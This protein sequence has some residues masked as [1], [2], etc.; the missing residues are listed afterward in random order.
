MGGGIDY[1]RW[2]RED[3]ALAVSGTGRAVDVSTYVG[4]PGT[5]T[6]ST[7]ISAF[8]AGVRWYPVT[9]PGASIRP[10]VIGQLGAYVG[11]GTA[12]ATGLPG[13]VV[14][15]EVL[16]APGVY[17]GGGVDFRFG[18]TFVLGVGIGGDLPANFSEEL[19]GTKNYRAFQVGISFGFTFGKGRTPPAATATAGSGPACIHP[20]EARVAAMSQSKT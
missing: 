11:T 18:N 7:T 3:L 19:A 20:R 12:T 16:V 9:E 6:E 2:F 14:R 10:Y 15:N 4:F 13:T 1:Y 8:L 17:L 5:Y